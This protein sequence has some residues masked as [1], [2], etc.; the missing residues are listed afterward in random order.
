M[1]QLHP[2]IPIQVNSSLRDLKITEEIL[3]WYP[4]IS[5]LKNKNTWLALAQFWKPNGVFPDMPLPGYEYYIVSGDS[6]MFGLAEKISQYTGGKVIQLSGPLF[7]SD[8]T[9]NLVNY[10]PYTNDHRRLARIP[11]RWTIQKDIKYK[12]SA[13]TNRVTQSK[14]IIFSALISLFNEQDFVGSLNHAHNELKNV[15]NWAMSGNTVCDY[16]TTNFIDNWLDKKITLPNDDRTE[17]SYNNPAYQNSALNFT[18][19]SYHY[20]YMVRDGIHCIEP[21]PFLTEKTW[22]CLL[23]KTAFIPVGQMDSYKW[24]QQMGMKFD[25]GP[26]DLSFDQDSRNLTRL[27]KIVNLIKSLNQWTAHELF[28]MTRDSCEYN[29]EHVLD[30]NFW[31]N[32]EK[33]NQSTHKLLSKLC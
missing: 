24:L 22:K 9:T 4:W 2:Y 11:A 16:Y 7:N 12:V 29:Y 25:Y 19:E 20:S 3:Y 23:S 33:Y 32:C 21:G 30:R 8:L 15:H 18:Q 14:A 5:D 31:E 10:V 17:G 6:L 1:I 27:E 26:M 13:L 28:E